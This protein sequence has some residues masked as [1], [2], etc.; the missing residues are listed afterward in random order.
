MVEREICEKKR[1]I[2]RK[3]KILSKNGLGRE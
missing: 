1:W 2:K 3:E